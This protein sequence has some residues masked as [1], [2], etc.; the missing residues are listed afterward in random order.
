M[1]HEHAVSELRRTMRGH[2]SA[3]LK[4]TLR[5]MQKEFS[6]VQTRQTY[7]FLHADEM[8][9][10]AV[11]AELGRLAD[12]GSRLWLITMAIKEELHARWVYWHSTHAP[13]TGFSLADRATIKEV[14]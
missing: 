1:D 7:L 6:A 9:G 14:A 12:D 13:H 3:E 2:R 11:D 5:D 10:E 4:R 8:D